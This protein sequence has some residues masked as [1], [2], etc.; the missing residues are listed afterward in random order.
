MH[1]SK[2]YNVS[3]NDASTSEKIMENGE[4]KFFSLFIIYIYMRMETHAGL[5]YKLSYYLYQLN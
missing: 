4:L 5:R 1:E 3:H 2:E